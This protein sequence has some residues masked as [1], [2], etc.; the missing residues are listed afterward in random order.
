MT[1][2]SYT[3]FSPQTRNISHTELLDII[4]ILIKN[5]KPNIIN[6]NYY[7]IPANMLRDNLSYNIPAAN[8]NRADI[9]INSSEVPTNNNVN[10]LHNIVDNIMNE[11]G[12]NITNSNTTPSNNTPSNNT[13]SNNTHSNNTNIDLSNIFETTRE[14]IISNNITPTNFEIYISERNTTEEPELEIDNI[15]NNI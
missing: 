11:L 8:I 2:S 3:Q 6:H 4:E 7:Q 12:N 14:N 13:H 9:P 1:N 15:H 5:I 10:N